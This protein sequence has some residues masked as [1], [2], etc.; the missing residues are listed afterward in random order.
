[1]EEGL[2]S[3][4]EKSGIEAIEAFVL[5]DLIG[6]SNPTFHDMFAATTALFQRIVK[7]G[8]CLC[9]CVYVFMLCLFAI[10]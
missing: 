8:G 2:L 7:I 9:G 5:L 10:A 4:G 6:A 1:M 3:V